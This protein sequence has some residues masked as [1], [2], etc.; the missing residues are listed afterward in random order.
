MNKLLGREDQEKSFIE[1]LCHFEKNKNNCLTKRGIYVYGN[2]GSGKSHFVISILKKLNY[3]IIKYDAGDV[4]NKNVIKNLARSN[5]SDRSIISMFQKKKRNI[6]IVMDEIDGMNNGD[7]GGINCLIKLIRPKKTK[8]QKKEETTMIPIVCIGNYHKDKKIKEIMKICVTIEL[9]TPENKTMKKIIRTMMPN[10][11]LDL[12]DKITEFIQGDLR[13]LKSTYQ[14]YENN[15]KTLENHIMH[16]LFKSREYSEDTKFIVQKILTNYY[17]LECHNSLMNDTE[18]TSVGLLVHENIIDLIDDIPKKKSIPFYLE[19]LENIS[20]ADYI[21]R[22]TFQKQ[23]WILNEL[24][25]LIKTFYNH[26]LYH[27]KFKYKNK[28]VTI[29]PEGIRFTKILTKYSTEYNNILFVDLLCSQLFLDKK[30]MLS[31]FVDLM[32]K[33]SIDEIFSLFIDDNYEISKLDIQRLIKYLK[34]YTINS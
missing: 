12:C 21:D 8:K 1:G 7:K 20:F 16:N 33:F 25:S 26:F 14:I 2:P 29:K 11:E 34:F 13:K 15:Q 32:Q 9:K 10:L 27:K 3:D 19:I 18:R 24:S 4:R 31:Y 5:M 6:V 28:S 30:D 22:I 17:P 23:I